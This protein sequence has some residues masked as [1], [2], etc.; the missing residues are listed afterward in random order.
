MATVRGRWL[1]AAL[2]L[3]LLLIAGPA[4]AHEHVIVGDYEFT[5]GW[6]NEPAITG[7]V[8]GLDL[9]VAPAS[10]E[11]AG[12]SHAE[13]EAEGVTGLDET[14]TF[15]VEYGGVEHKYNLR[16]AFGRPGG[17][18]AEFLPTRPGQYT[19]HFTGSVEEQ[20][21]D[22]QIEPEEVQDSADLSF[23][24]AS[25][26]AAGMEKGL[27]TALTLAILGVLLG[28]AGTILGLTARRRP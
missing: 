15:T 17:Y 6:L 3:T 11:G 16:P 25:T 5:V 22:V 7:Q 4:W 1:G 23:P 27:A 8:N 14:L 10:E 19:F 24:E 2:G 21:V 13:E 26:S 12:E 28:A 20:T 18:H 9:F